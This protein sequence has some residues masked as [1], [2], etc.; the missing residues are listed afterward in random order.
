MLKLHQATTCENCGVYRCELL[1]MLKLHQ[2]STLR[3]DHVL[4]SYD[5][6]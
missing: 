2:A 6:I 5:T 4:W 1:I 3:L